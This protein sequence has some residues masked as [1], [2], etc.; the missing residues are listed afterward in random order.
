MRYSKHKS[1]LFYTRE[2]LISN[3]GAS[4]I[5]VQVYTKII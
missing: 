4:D 1:P 5:A 3:V 2:P